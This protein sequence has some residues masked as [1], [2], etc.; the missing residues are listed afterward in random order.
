MYRDELIEHFKN[1]H[2]FGTIKKPDLEVSAI[3]SLCGDAIKITI[4]ENNGVVSDIKFIGSGCAI[5]TAS[6]SMLTDYLKGKTVKEI[7][8]L[9]DMKVL[10]DLG[11]EVTPARVKCALL[12]IK[13]LKSL[14]THV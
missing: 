6:A 11:I 3:N 4:K 2:N 14:D 10:K 5:S 1:P 13:A 7:K 8:S 12:P 9:E